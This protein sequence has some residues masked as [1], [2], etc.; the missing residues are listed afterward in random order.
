MKAG[1]I[2]ND[3]LR[4]AHFIV[5]GEVERFFIYLTDEEMFSYLQN[6]NNG[7]EALNRDHGRLTITQEF[8]LGRAKSV[9][10][11]IK[12]P[13]VVCSARNVS[14]RDVGRGQRLS[15]YFVEPE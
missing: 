10:K 15:I 4:L 1:A 9:R 7:F 5:P 6:P 11:M 14:S 12:V 13:P 3:L 2:L 8:V